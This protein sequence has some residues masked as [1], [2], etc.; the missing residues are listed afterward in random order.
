MTPFSIAGI[1][2]HVSAQSSNVEAMKHRIEIAMARFGWIDMILFSELAPY[3][4]LISNHPDSLKDDIKLFQEMARKYKIWLIPGSMFERRK[5]KIY[6]TSVVINP[7]GEIVGR[8]DKMFPFMPYEIGVEGGS[9]FL[10]FDVP[11][12]GRFGLSIC[13]DIWFPE[14]SRTLASMG[15]EVLLHPV[16]TGTTDRDVELAMARATGAQFQCYVFDING[17]G[18]GGLGRSCVV[19]PGGNL[20]YEA[21]GN[22][23]I[24][25]IEIDLD[26]VR[27][28]RAMGQNGLGQVQKSF[29]DRNVDFDVYDTESF[30]HSYQN[31]LG[32]LNM[33]GRNHVAEKDPTTDDAKAANGTATSGEYSSY[34]PSNQPQN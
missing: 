31:S 27:R 17:I 3:G 4:P 33:P 25:P 21:R 28:Q 6:N 16:L 32:P 1:Q 2:M 12:I 15:A 22:E 34:A 11:K 23:E 7:Q 30:D 18:A 20:L 5:G 8:Y 13:Y 26:V 9:E 14:T 29:R 24:I 19:G 10:V